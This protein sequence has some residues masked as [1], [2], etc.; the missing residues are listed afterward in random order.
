MAEIPAWQR[1]LAARAAELDAIY[2]EKQLVLNNPASTEA[3]KERAI[4]SALCKLRL[5]RKYW[6][7]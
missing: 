4:D 2:D 6:P 7:L 1:S 3:Q 5:L